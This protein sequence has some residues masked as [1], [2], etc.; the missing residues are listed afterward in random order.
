MAAGRKSRRQITI[1]LHLIVLRM[2]K[3]IQ[4]IRTP[5][6]LPGRQSSVVCTGFPPP[7]MPPILHGARLQL[8]KEI[9]IHG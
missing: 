7:T 6:P 1:F 5:G 3:H 8:Q 4:R 2:T 9:N